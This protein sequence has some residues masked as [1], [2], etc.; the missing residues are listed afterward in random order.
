MLSTEESFTPLYYKPHSDIRCGTSQLFRRQCRNDLHLDQHFKFFAYME[1]VQLRLASV[2]L[3][4][5][6]CSLMT[7]ESSLA[8]VLTM[9]PVVYKG[10]SPV[11]MNYR[12]GAHLDTT[13]V[14][15]DEKGVDLVQLGAPV[16]IQRITSTAKQWRIH[17][18]RVGA[19]VP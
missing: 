11:L 13:S 7:N 15:R 6:I 19:K 10:Q 2:T 5:I 16:R 9:Y 3:L 12:H 17:H 18:C 1:D 8:S 4:V 14:K